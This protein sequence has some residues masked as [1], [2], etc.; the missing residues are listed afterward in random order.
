[1][2]EKFSTGMVNAI[3]EAIRTSLTD[4]VIGIFNGTQPANADATEGSANLLCLITLNGGAF[5][6]GQAANGLEFGAASGGVISKPGGDVWKG[7]GLAAAGEGG[8]TATWF[9]VYANAYTTGASSSAVR[10]DGAI[11][12]SASY[13]LRMTNPVV[14]Q[15]VETTISAFSLT[16]PMS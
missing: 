10:Y 8:T 16:V 13:E 2:A 6:A 15:G 12:T 4:C 5:T 1:M 11:G 9:R 7:T 14:V 3:G